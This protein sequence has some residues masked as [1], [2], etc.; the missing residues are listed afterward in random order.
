M[1]K[2]NSLS[3]LVAAKRQLGY[4]FLSNGLF[5]NDFLFRNCDCDILFEMV[6]CTGSF[7]PRRQRQFLLKKKK[8]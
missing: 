3:I 6:S 1:N 8:R 7:T 5:T 4:M 2:Y